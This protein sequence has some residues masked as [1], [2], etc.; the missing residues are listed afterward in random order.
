MRSY[1]RSKRLPSGTRSAAVIAAMRIP[2]DTFC[3]L[4]SNGSS[5]PEA[6]RVA[7]AAN[8]AFL[9][10]GG[11]SLSY[12]DVFLVSAL[13]GSTSLDGPCVAGSIAVAVKKNP[14]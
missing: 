1:A 9:T 3:L 4:K 2:P 7:T 8:P 10:K 5:A 13:V 6:A 11:A 14:K 12:G